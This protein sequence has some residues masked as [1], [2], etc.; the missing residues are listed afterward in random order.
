MSDDTQTPDAVATL[1]RQYDDTWAHPWESLE[2]ALKDVTEDEAAWQAPIYATE[3]SEEGW[4]AKG[5]VRWHVA[6]LAACKRDYACL[7]RDRGKAVDRSEA[8]FTPGESYAADLAQLIEAHQWLR[9]EVAAMAPAELALKLNEKV[10]ADE[11]IAA[12]I[13]HDAWH[14][15]QIIVARRLYRTH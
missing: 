4:P 7:V 10:P 5:S 1:L 11:F 15:G 9:R 13:R 8:A 3:P 6:H 2:V 14:A 12:T